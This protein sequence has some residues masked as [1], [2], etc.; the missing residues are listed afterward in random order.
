VKK[1]QKSFLFARRSRVAWRFLE[2]G[3]LKLRQAQ[4]STKDR[5]NERIKKLFTNQPTP[6][7]FLF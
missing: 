1:S 5:K 4:T 6:S 3:G 7:L 2:A